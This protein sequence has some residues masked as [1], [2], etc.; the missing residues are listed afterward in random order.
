MK[1]W[2]AIL[3]LSVVLSLALGATSGERV[4]IKGFYQED[5]RF[6]RER[7]VDTLPPNG[8]DFP[9]LEEA[10][11]ARRRQIKDFY[12]GRVVKARISFPACRSGVS[13]RVDNPSQA[14][15]TLFRRIHKFGISIGKEETAVITGLA[16]HKSSID[17]D[18]NGGG[19]GTP[20]DYVK[21]TLAGVVTVGLSEALVDRTG[22]RTQRGSRLR[23]V[24]DRP[25][26]AETLT[27]QRIEKW[28]APLV[29]RV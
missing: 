28:L 29:E 14:N 20:W 1:E 5:G 9:P 26:D 12:E 21:R 23:L 6:V 17:I 4:K 25:L 10:L 7:V 16:V 8:R 15:V 22:S 27:F 2:K 18:L 19:Y 11:P 24:S 13:L 3:L